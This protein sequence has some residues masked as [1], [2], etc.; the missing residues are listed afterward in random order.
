MRRKIPSTTALLCFEAA[1]KCENFALAAQSINMSQSAFSR[2]VQELEKHIGQS[3]FKRQRQRV[4]LTAVGRM[5]AGELSPLLEQMEIS[6][7]QA[8]S[9]TNPYGAINIGTYP[10]LGSRWLMPLLAVFSQQQARTTFN[11]ITY[12]D[13]QQI[14]DN[15]I[16]ICIAQGD[17]PWSGY[18][19]D[20][21]MLETLVVV[22]APGVQAGLLLGGEEELLEQR[23]LQH[24]TRPE[25]WRIWFN[26]LHK[27][28]PMEPIGPWFSQY[29]ML[30]SA[31]KDGLGIALIPELLVTQEL[32]KGELVLAHPHKVTPPSGYY[33]LTPE[34]KVGMA[35]IEAFRQ[36]IL[37]RVPD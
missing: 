19:A 20:F 1:A 33:L 27:T 7:L 6:L 10:T 12:L 8:S 37:N 3:L 16:D 17:P 22:A 4:Y 34:A 36:W 5:L 30:I 25:S 28:L 35:R 18:R 23:I 13:N 9:H 31:V 14:D 24:S 21:L 32:S 29:E 11:T 26:S 15:V 2:Q